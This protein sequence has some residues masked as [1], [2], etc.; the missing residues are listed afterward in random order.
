VV[1]GRDP[2]TD[3]LLGNVG[4]AI[5]VGLQHLRFGKGGAFANLVERAAGPVRDAAIE[6]AVGIAVEGATG[7]IG[8]VLVNVGQFEGLAVVIGGVAAAMV[9]R[10][11]TGRSFD[12]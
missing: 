3:K 10:T 9:D 1:H 2:I 6:V 11:A 4:E 7:R 8:R 5:A 12:T